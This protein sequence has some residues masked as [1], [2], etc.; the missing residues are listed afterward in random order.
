MPGSG[1]VAFGLAIFLSLAIV[2]QL[3]VIYLQQSMSPA[4][5]YALP[6]PPGLPLSVLRPTQAFCKA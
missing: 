5:Q 4:A 1:K 6:A 2:G 3:I